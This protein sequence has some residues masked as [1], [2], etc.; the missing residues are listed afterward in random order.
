M[1]LIEPKQRAGDGCGPEGRSLVR[2]I[3]LIEDEPAVAG[4]VRIVL[5]DEGYRVCVAQ[6]GKA[7]LQLVRETHPDLVLADMMMPVLDGEAVARSIHADPQLA[8]VP[9][10]LMSAGRGPTPDLEGLYQAFL[11]KPFELDTLL[12]VVARQ[13]RSPTTRNEQR[14]TR[15]EDENR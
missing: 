14:D 9:V 12:D 15:T 11:S 6:N 13:I 3:V 10:V 1:A 5:Q 8:D 2:D 4:M 7:G